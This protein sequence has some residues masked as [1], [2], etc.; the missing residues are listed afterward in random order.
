MRFHIRLLEGCNPKVELGSSV[1]FG[2]FGAQT[3]T[4]D[5]TT[6]IATRTPLPN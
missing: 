4:A 2:W 5:W 6:D 1:L 3:T